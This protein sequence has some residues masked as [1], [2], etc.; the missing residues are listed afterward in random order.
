MGQCFLS[1]TQTGFSPQNWGENGDGPVPADN[2][3]DGKADFAVWR[4]T[5]GTW[6]IVNS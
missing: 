3:G 1:R 5:N 2:Y 6:Y 4:P